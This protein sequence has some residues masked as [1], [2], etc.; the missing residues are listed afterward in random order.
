MPGMHKSQ[1]W[2]LSKEETGKGG[3]RRN[4]SK[5]ERRSQKRKRVEKME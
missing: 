4:G 3:G 5:R 2:I 1:D